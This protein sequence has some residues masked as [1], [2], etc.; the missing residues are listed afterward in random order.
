MKLGKAFGRGVRVGFL[1]EKTLLRL[2]TKYSLVALARRV[3]AIQPLRAAARIIAA[4]R[5]IER[6]VMLKLKLYVGRSKTRR[7]RAGGAGRGWVKSDRCLRQRCRTKESV[8]VVGSGQNWKRVRVYSAF[9]RERRGCPKRGLAQQR[10]FGQN[11][12]TRK[13]RCARRV[14]ALV[15][16]YGKPA[17][18]RRAARG[19][20]S[21][22]AA[23][24]AQTEVPAPM[25]RPSR[26]KVPVPVAKRQELHPVVLFGRRS[27]HSRFPGE[28]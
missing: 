28:A 3:R 11:R 23:T 20:S 24:L 12:R 15:H 21:P 9:A 25:S 26:R 5:P 22:T 14:G 10:V 2:A 6:G 13:R 7:V 16:P 17:A 19:L 18:T 27:S 8:S 1:N 4:P